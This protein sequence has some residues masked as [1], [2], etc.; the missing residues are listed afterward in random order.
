MGGYSCQRK[1][2]SKTYKEVY[3]WCKIP[4]SYASSPTTQTYPELFYGFYYSSYGLDVGI[5]QKNGGWIVT[6]NF[7]SATTYNNE[8][9]W[10]EYKVNG[11]TVVFNL[12]PDDLVYMHAWVTLE[13][14]IYYINFYMSKT[15]RNG[16]DLMS[17]YKR[18][19]SNAAGSRFY[20]SGAEINREIA[21]ASNSTNYESCGAYCL[22]A[23][24]KACGLKTASGTTYTWTPNLTYKWPGT[25]TN[26]IY[27]DSASKELRLRKDYY[28]VNASK[29][30][31]TKSTD[32]SGAAIETANINFS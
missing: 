26:E 15:G 25:N 24:W 4:T 7:N 19:L 13:N 18:K 1:T 22:N 14:S 3:G 17:T 23:Q 29:I 20:N 16:T 32:T 11:N 9:L 30:N 5:V 12:S 28:T 8:P 2:S 6:T 21:L 31:A 27:V 10:G